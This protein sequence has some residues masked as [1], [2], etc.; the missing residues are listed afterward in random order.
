MCD[1][2]LHKVTE[3]RDK[4]NSYN[5]HDIGNLSFR[6]LDIMAKLSA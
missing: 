1:P 6:I 4:I 3:S 5:P 2:A